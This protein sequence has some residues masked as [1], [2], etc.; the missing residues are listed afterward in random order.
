MQHLS[1]ASYTTWCTPIII[2]LADLQGCVHVPQSEKH[3][4]NMWRA[5]GDHLAGEQSYRI[6]VLWKTNTVVVGRN[7]GEIEGSA[8]VSIQWKF[9]T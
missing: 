2:L 5:I 8:L 7:I 3:S 4:S 9:I 1:T 6:Y